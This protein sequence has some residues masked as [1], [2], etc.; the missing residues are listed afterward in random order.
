MLIPLV[1]ASAS[2]AGCAGLEN[3][4]DDDAD[5]DFDSIDLDEELEAIIM[6]SDV[7]C[8]ASGS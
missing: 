6:G 3:D 1:M 5:A 8:C 4:Y 7:S 2:D